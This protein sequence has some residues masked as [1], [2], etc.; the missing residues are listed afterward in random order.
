M[1]DHTIMT[2][3]SDQCRLDTYFAGALC[4]TRR[5]PGHVGGLVVI[6]GAVDNPGEG[7]ARD[8]LRDSCASGPGARPACW[9]KSGDVYADRSCADYVPRCEGDT[10][11]SCGPRSGRAPIDCAFLGMKCEPTRGCVDP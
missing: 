10:F 9:F 1:K 7:R 8:A 5:E 3:A 4:A 6:D 2:Y 11:L